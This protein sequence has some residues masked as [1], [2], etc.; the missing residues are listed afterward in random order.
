MEKENLDLKA[1][2]VDMEI[3]IDKNEQYNRKTSL[4][5]GGMAFPH[6]QLIVL[7]LPQTPGQWQLTSSKR[8]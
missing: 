8:N 5:L 3:N 7:K 1:K 6:P 4:I 2:V